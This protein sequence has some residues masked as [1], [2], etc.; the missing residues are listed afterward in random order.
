MQAGSKRRAATIAARARGAAAKTRE[1]AQLSTR[2][3][4]ARVRRATAAALAILLCEAASA[5]ASTPQPL[6]EEQMTRAAQA[7]EIPLNI[8]YSVGLTETGHEGMLSPYDMNVDGRAVLSDS[9]PQALARFEYERARGAK[10]ID[11][12]CM[13]IN[14]R[15]HGQNFHSLADM[16]DPERNVEYAASFLKTLRAQEGFW[17]LAVARYNA[18]PEI[19]APNANTSAR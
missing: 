4:R 19:P 7:Y 16:F 5:L 3:A 2:R 11:V 9:L 1:S 18:G 8:L 6:C 15:W 14:H 12:G 17:T 10:L 13:Q